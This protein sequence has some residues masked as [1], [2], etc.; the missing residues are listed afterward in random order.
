MAGVPDLIVLKRHR[1]VDYVGR[2][3]PLVRRVVLALIALVSILG[4]LN[5]F[6]Q[7]PDTTIVS[8]PAASLKLYAPEHLRGGLLLERALPHPREA[9]AEGRDPRA[10]P[11]W[12]EG[13][14]INTIE[15]RPI[16]EASRDGKLVLDLGHIPAGQVLHPLH[17][18]PGEPDQR[19]VA[20]VAE[21]RARRRRQARSS[22]STARDD[23]PLVMD[24]VLRAVVV[25]VFVLVLTRVI[26]RRELSALAAVR[27]DPPDHP[28]RCAP[29]GPDAGRLLRHGRGARRRDVRGAA[30][31]RL[32]AR[33]SL[34]AHCGRSSRASRDRGR[35]TARRSSGT[36]A[37]SG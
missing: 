27:P 31:V 11:G 30:G 6:G 29:A 4:L 15:P 5:V 32:V 25:F 37:A 34:P 10:R 3:G 14:T 26:G 19:R 36:S 22:A 24:L 18:D 20:P 7:R 16:G 23:L 35:R 28:R 1:D 2:H 13:M 17:A 12:A 9:G 21:R 8:A 33:L